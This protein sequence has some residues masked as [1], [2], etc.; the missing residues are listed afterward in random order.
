[1][2]DAADGRA[3]WVDEP[4]DEYKAS[5]PGWDKPAP[6]PT[7]PARR[8]E[9]V[10]MPSI[11]INK[12]PPR[13]WA[14]GHYLMFG[15][16]SMLAAVDGGGK[17][18]QT[19]AIIL[20]FITGRPLLNER[21]WR[22]GPVAIIT[23][24]DDIEEWQRRI[25]AASIHYGISY[26]FALQNIRFLRRL[27]DEGRISFG[28]VDDDGK[29]VC[30]D[31]DDMV[32]LLKEMGAVAL[33]VD[34][35]NHAHCLPDGNNNVGMAKVAGEIDRI[36][37]LSGCAGLVLHHVRKSST[38]SLD[39]I[40]GA[41]SLR[42]T[43]RSSRVLIKMTE[44]DARKLNIKDHWRYSQV[45]SVKANFAPPP[46]QAVWFRIVSVDLNNPDELYTDGDS[47]G[48]CTPWTPRPLFEGMDTDALAA[49]F[50]T[51]R[52]TPHSSKKQAENWAGDVIMKIGKR[53]E[54]EAKVILNK[55]IDNGVLTK[56]QHWAG[57][58]RA[59]ALLLDEA[60]VAEIIKGLATKIHEEEI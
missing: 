3:A 40:M 50:S 24:E 11:P 38:G 4:D 8:L 23:Y 32:A 2:N 18:F 14:Y 6:D 30:L 35:F 17:G 51:L 44:E 21:V 54:T 7:K 33:S 43:F 53:S 10:G 27:D 59:E 19:T 9:C 45:A 22:S 48:V 41:T 31:R 60:K 26:D 29:V 49:I 25:A 36:C 52:E 42:A 39:D 5:H 46:E 1:M 34:P 56:G 12:I 37:A 47:V 16:A 58:N 28:E 13:P 15:R 57:R 55:W 20:S